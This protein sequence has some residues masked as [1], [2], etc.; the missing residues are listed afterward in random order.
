MPTLIDSKSFVKAAPAHNAVTARGALLPANRKS[1]PQNH[2]KNIQSDGTT[3]THSIHN[4]G[5]DIDWVKFRL[6]R[7]SN[8]TIKTYGLSGD[9]RMW[10]Y[11]ANNSRRRINYN[12]DG[13]NGYFSKI[14]RS[15]SRA[16]GPGTY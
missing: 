6:T 15:G 9:T 2:T 7:R 1:K 3:Q 12:D 14:T 13:G 16:L 10:L 11:G 5:R 8:V 4:N